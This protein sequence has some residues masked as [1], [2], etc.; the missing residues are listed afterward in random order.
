VITYFAGVNT[1]P[2]CEAF[3]GLHVLESFA[4]IV[5]LMDRHRPNFASMCLDSGA[6]SVMTTGKQ[7][8]LR[9]YIAFA[10]QHGGFYDFV[11]SLD[12]ITGGVKA[13]VENWRAMRDAGVDAMPTYHS[14]EPIELLTAYCKRTCRIGLGM[15][16]PGG[17][18]P[19]NAIVRQFLRECFAVIPP[20]VKVHGWGMTNFTDFPFWSVDSTTWLWEMK[21]LLG[22]RGQGAEVIACLT[23]RELIEMVQKKYLRFSK[24]QKWEG[25]Y[26]SKDQQEV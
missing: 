26:E 14:G 18:W 19:A 7:I 21:A 12:S 20:T 11:A 10:K 15:Q 13:N 8:D 4:D 2:F 16:R 9:E 1:N 23:P 22:A 5:R 3:A 24:R 6:Y 25:F 17:K